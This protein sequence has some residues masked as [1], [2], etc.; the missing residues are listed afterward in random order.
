MTAEHW[1]AAYAAA[2]QHSWDQ[3]T[4]AV[5]LEMLDRG[6]LRPTDSV[7]DVG[8]GDGVFTQTLLA[9]GHD[10]LT[11][12]DIADSALDAGR[13]RLGAHRDTV[14]WIRADVRTWTPERSWRIWHD[15]AAF[16]FLTTDQDREEYRHALSLATAADSLVC[17]GTFADDGPTHCSGLPVARYTEADLVEVLRGD[18][19]DLEPLSTAREVHRTPQGA[20]QHF[21]WAL[22]RRIN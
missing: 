18:A 15:R 16:H 5:D 13:Q 17:V 7:V 21:V 14:V 1:Q 22:L 3:T 11:V 10:D 2:D 9:R 20:E 6:G 19:L 4:P 8:G 12:L